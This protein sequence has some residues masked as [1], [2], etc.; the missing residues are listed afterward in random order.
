M[1]YMKFKTYLYSVC[2]CGL[3]MHC[4]CMFVCMFIYPYL[5]T[6]AKGHEPFTESLNEPRARLAARK[7]LPLTVVEL[8][9]HT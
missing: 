7:P 3:F 8:P 5:G 1:F 6:E 9:V 4:I 2:V